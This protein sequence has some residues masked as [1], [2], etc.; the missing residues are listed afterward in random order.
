MKNAPDTSTF[1]MTTDE[2]AAKPFHDI[3]HRW[4]AEDKRRSLQALREDLENT[5]TELPEYDPDPQVF[6][7]T[8]QL[9][10]LTD[11]KAMLRTMASSSSVTS[12][13]AYSVPRE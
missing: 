5:K 1:G 11:S 12:A 3:E 10:I 6:C 9:M 13:Y 7:Q 2:L 4:S 8:T